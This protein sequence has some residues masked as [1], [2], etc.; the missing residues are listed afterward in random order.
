MWQSPGEG[1]DVITHTVRAGGGRIV[2]MGVGEPGR[3]SI[4][5]VLYRVGQGLAV[6]QPLTPPAPMLPSW[7]KGGE[8]EKF[9]DR[10]TF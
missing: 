3:C 4:S 8:I 10:F 1:I 6:E 2:L 7:R 9:S 5:Y